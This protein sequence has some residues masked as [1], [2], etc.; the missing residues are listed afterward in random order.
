[1]T[2]ENLPGR[3]LVTDTAGL[4]IAF[5]DVDTVQSQ[6]IRLAYDMAEA[7]HDPDA[8]DTVAARHLTEAGT[9]AFGYVAAAALRMLARHVLDP[10][11]DVTDALHDHGRGP[12][13]HDLRAGLA[14]AARNARQ[15]LS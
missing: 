4:P 2:T 14:D 8:L 10:V 13:Q 3:L 1:M 5:V 12:L 7:C 6:A 9:D 15:E 11:L